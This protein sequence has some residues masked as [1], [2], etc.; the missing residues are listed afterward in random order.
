MM[1]SKKTTSG[2]NIKGLWRAVLMQA[3]IDVTTKSRNRRAKNYRLK[4]QNWLKEKQDVT[5]IET[6]VLADMEP[7]YVKM[8]V[9]KFFKKNQIS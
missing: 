3:L 6:C 5:F 7:N 8:Q 9:N 4:A 1:S 2:N